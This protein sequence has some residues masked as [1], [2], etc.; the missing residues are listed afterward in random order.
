MLKAQ[1][2][3]LR[4]TNEELEEKARLL[5]NEK[6][7]VEEKNR[8]VE[9]AKAALEEKAEQLALT[10]R[11]KSEFLANMSHELRTPLNSLLMLSRL[12]AENVEGN[13]TDKEISFARTIHA[14]GSELLSLI[15]DILDLSKIE[16]G[17]VTLD[18]GEMFLSDLR[19][20]MERT[21]S[22]VA[23]DKGLEFSIEIDPDLRPSMRT[24]DKRLQQV[25]RNLLSNAFKF[26]E[27]G[28]VTL[29]AERADGGWSFDHPILNAADQVVAISVTDTGVGI[30]EDKQQI[31][32][33]AFQQADGTTNRKYGGTGLGLSISREL[34]GLLGGEIM[35][36]S[37]YG[38]GS[39]FTLFLP[40]QFPSLPA[41]GR[42]SGGRRAHGFAADTKDR[43]VLSEP[44]MLEDDRHDVHV[45]DAV[46]VI[47][48]DDRDHAAAVLDAAHQCGFKALVSSVEYAMALVK[49]SR[50]QVIVLGIDAP[51]KDGWALLD[52]VRHDKLLRHIPVHVV[53]SE[54]NR[55]RALFMGAY[56]FSERPA[57]AGDLIAGI[58]RVREF[59]ARAD[60]KLLVYAPEAEARSNLAGAVADD[61]VKV[62]EAATAEEVL[63]RLATDPA[64]G[65]VV[66]LS[67][68]TDEGI[69]LIERVRADDRFADLAIVAFTESDTCAGGAASVRALGGRHAV[70]RAGSI[71]RLADEAALCLHRAIGELP[72]D[73]RA[74]LQALPQKDPALAGRKI[75]IIDDDFR[76]IFSLTS[77]LEQHEMEVLYAETG[78]EGIEML[79][80]ITDVDLALIDVM[81]PEMDGY[82]TMRQIRSLDGLADLPLIA[83]TAKAMKGDREKC[84]EA[85]ASDYLA[86]PVDI[87]RLVSMLRVW[88]YR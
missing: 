55:R 88:L 52:L 27:T 39:T 73:R 66:D 24:D 45:G 16:S 40:V 33:E 46:I 19:E 25:I 63:A 36:R 77:A 7:Q 76:N 51:D 42:E 78:K 83:V 47:V 38:Q 30:A 48:E 84:I 28:A 57:A 29:R 67:Q 17:T 41:V 62:T 61:H 21:F 85:G 43:M 58:Q 65:L 26:T 10:S 68:A 59:I 64:D 13:L 53:S 71:D 49:R 11:Y 9:L 5:S 20:R 35:L 56:G 32:F 18:I 74:A 50:P 14:G 86:K 82:E 12:L 70:R 15:N 69:E 60:R 72:A 75:V 22:Q 6:K 23:L 79:Q 8:E 54:E 4:K 87:D 81:M 44:P 3:E 34:A 31:I 37:T 2:E 80:S 1:Q